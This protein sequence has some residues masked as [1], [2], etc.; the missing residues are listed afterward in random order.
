LKDFVTILLIFYAFRFT[1]FINV[2]ITQRPDRRYPF[3]SG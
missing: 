2:M 3:F 1:I